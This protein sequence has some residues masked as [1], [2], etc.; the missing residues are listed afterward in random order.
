M[1]AVTAL[2][3]A[4]GERGK[5]NNQPVVA[6]TELGVKA[7]VGKQC[8]ATHHN[9]TQHNT[10][11]HN[12][13]Q[14]KCAVAATGLQEGKS[15]CN[16]QSTVGDRSNSFCCGHTTEGSPV[17]DDGTVAIA[18]CFRMFQNTTTT[19]VAVCRRHST[20]LD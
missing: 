8:T 12:T 14:C 6:V 2:T 10:T 19:I 15:K 3:L 7:A 5:V 1:A 9:T 18:C 17:D 4:E 20:G 13:T 16:N 11:Q